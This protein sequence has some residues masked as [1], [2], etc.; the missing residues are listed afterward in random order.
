MSFSDAFLDEVRS[1]VP[2]S[3]VVGRKV[4]LTRKGRELWGLCPF[5]NEK[6]SSFKVND[7][8]QRYHCFGCGA[9]GTAFDFLIHTEGL[10]FRESVTRLAR[11]AGLDLPTETPEQREADKRR[12]TLLDANE[13]AAKWF[14]EQLATPAAEEAR[15][16]LAGRG[17]PRAALK[18][19]RLGYAPESRNALKGALLA[20]G[21]DEALQIEAGLLVKPEEGGLAYDRFRG[22]ITFPI[23]DRQGRIVAFGARALGDQQPKY[24][25]SPET[26]LFSKGRQLYNLGP[27]RAAARQGLP[28]IVAEGYM[29][30][31]ALVQAE[32]EAAVAPLGT[33]L[34]ED[35]LQE[36]WRLA[37][38]P[39]L[40]LDGD[41]AGRKAALRAA[42]RALP[43]L[44][45]GQSLRFALLP[46]EH[47][48]DSLIRKS[49]KGAMQ[50]ALDAAKPLADLLWE[51][52]TEGRELSTPERQAAL[53]KRLFAD[54]AGRIGD[55]TVRLYY[56]RLF[57]QR[58]AALFPS[59]QRGRLGQDRRQG[60]GRPG[61]FQLLIEARP[62]S[63]PTVADAKR[64][65]A[66]I[67]ALVNHPNILDD[68]F[69]DIA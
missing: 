44:K 9:D 30:V 2:V 48:P 42:E 11:E 6:T 21:I 55:Q 3:A 39:T 50:A 41:A 16:Y 4:K 20:Q 1:R 62:R 59:V 7:D 49:G 13:A 17:L 57:G 54:I 38:E 60:K 36:L 51:S 47:D 67:L 37:P 15:K 68:L 29:D 23:A 5:H 25:N 66:L 34:T 45:P 52:E 58:L 19:F 61:A 22:R 43:L 32:F 40:C 65:R 10:T 69:E 56:R 26:P 12:A 31:I 33:A 28:L 46:P 27:A 8:R 53:E 35:Q 14:E 18:R 63:L 24:L 64:E